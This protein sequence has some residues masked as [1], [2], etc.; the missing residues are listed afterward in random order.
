MDYRLLYIVHTSFAETCNDE[1]WS[2]SN[3]D[4][5]RKI[6]DLMEIIGRKVETVSLSPRDRDVIMQGPILETLFIAQHAPCEAGPRGK[7]AVV[8][9]VFRE[10]LR[11]ESGDAGRALEAL[12]EEC[13]NSTGGS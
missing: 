8:D 13:G 5:T 10:L 4:L 7:W 2:L 3:A 9:E 1:L 11:D 6:Q 12:R